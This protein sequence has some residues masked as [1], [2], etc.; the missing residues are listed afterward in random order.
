MSRTEPI[1]C[2]V[3]GLGRIASGLEDDALREKPATHAGAI[4][5]NPDTVLV[6]GSDIDPDAREAF[7]ERW[8][9]DALFAEAREMLQQL[10]PGILHIATHEDS[11]LDYLD[12]AMD[13]AVPVLVLEKPVSD[14]LRKARR[15]GRRLRAAG[16]TRVL[17][18]HERRYSL[19]YVA[20]REDVR[21]KRFGEL[22][23]VSGRIYMGRRRPVR[24]ILLHDGTHMLD[25]IPYLAGR[26]IRRLRVVP[27]S[28]K[29]RNVYAVARCGEADVLIEAGNH[30]DHL[31][32]ELELSFDKGRI[33][34]GNGIHE[35]WESRESPFYE[36]FNSLARLP[37]PPAQPTGYFARM[38]QDAVRVHDDPAALP[39]SS[40]EDGVESLAIVMAMRRRLK[41]I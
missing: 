41:R 2:A 18:N 31:V 12:M 34:I 17:V 11:H 16:T 13:E 23:S 21:K 8:G 1:R 5:A 20:V 10:K 39:L 4:A 28:R 9:V 25:I 14:S 6:G 35:I 24:D 22:V 30:R 27:S 37:N 38:L 32:F 7:S 15:A 40:F 19:D 36:N 3:I 26:P 33:R 29:P